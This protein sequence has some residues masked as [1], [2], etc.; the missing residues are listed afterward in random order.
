MVRTRIS[1][2]VKMMRGIVVQKLLFIRDLMPGHAAWKLL[3]QH[4]VDLLWSPN[5]IRS[6]KLDE[7][8]N[9]L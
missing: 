4:Q 1:G 9:S 8:S 6:T 3:I 7:F 2:Q 5:L